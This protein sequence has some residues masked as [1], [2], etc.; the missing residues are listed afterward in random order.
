MTSP[1]KTILSLSITTPNTAVAGDTIALPNGTRA[2][3]LLA[4]F[5]YGSGGTKT[6]AYVQ[7]SLDGGTTWIDIACV[8]FTTAS[9]NKL[10]NLSGLTA[11][12]T[13]YTPTD[14]TLTDDTTKDGILGD[15]LRVK[16]TTTGTYAGTTLVVVAYPR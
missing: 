12:G 2:V 1:A 3:N 11:L 9:A 8:T 15:L 5:T 6:T 7:T 4:K 14:G 10:I 16:Y 13:V